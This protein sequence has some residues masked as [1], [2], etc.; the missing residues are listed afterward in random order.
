VHLSC[1]HHLA[2][3]LL[4]QLAGAH[5]LKSLHA[6][7]TKSTFKQPK[8]RI[9][10][11]LQS[12]VGAVATIHAHG[13][14]A[15]DFQ[16]AVDTGVA[17]VGA[18]FAAAHLK[19][20]LVTVQFTRARCTPHVT[21]DQ[22]EGGRPVFNTTALRNIG[23]QA[24]FA[25]SPNVPKLERFA[26]C[27][28]GHGDFADFNGAVGVEHKSLLV[29]FGAR[30]SCQFQIV[31][32]FFVLLADVC[33]FIRMIVTANSERVRRIYIEYNDS[34]N[35]KTFLVPY[36]I[37]FD[38]CARDKLA[39]PLTRRRSFFAARAAMPR[40]NLAPGTVFKRF[41]A[42]RVK[43]L[44]ASSKCTLNGIL[45]VKNNEAGCAFDLIA[46]AQITEEIIAG[47]GVDAQAGRVKAAPAGATAHDKLP[48]VVTHAAVPVVIVLQPN[49]GRFR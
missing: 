4:H 12:T 13:R 3:V 14:V 15:L 18:G 2:N 26:P 9:G 47:H 6:V 8:L 46:P 20:L 17:A 5:I 24:V 48:D 31:A 38:A 27:F 37:T 42:S 40:A 19:I 7:A 35:W 29:F 10:A 49:G 16:G 11:L 39:R 28:V 34:F 22:S 32:F 41:H 30:K 25:E 33:L 44:V 36:M 43:V 21:L 1:S 23:A 45:D